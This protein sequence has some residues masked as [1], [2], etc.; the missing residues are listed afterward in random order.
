MSS[1]EWNDSFSS[2]PDGESAEGSPVKC[3]PAG[4][5]NGIISLA[6]FSKDTA[7]EL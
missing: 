6:K 3:Y 1:S 2:D 7:E 5:R 4:N